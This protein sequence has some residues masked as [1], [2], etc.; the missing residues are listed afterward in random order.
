MPASYY[1]R[2]RRVLLVVY[3]PERRRR[4]EIRRVRLRRSIHRWCASSLCFPSIASP[5]HER[6]DVNE[7]PVVL[8][9]GLTKNF[10]LPGW[11]VC[12]VIGPKNLVSALS[13]SGSFLD[14]G[15]SHP[16]QAAAIPFL[17][18]EYVKASKVTTTSSVISQLN[19]SRGRYPAALPPKAFLRQAEPRPPTPRRHGYSCTQPARCD[20]LYLARLVLFTIPSQ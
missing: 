19:S 12:W 16:L 8:I 17:D 15:A 10:R 6:I 7:D 11:R 4:T 5:D 3:L 20:I 18:K 14:G 9:D 1:A 2:S 13:Q